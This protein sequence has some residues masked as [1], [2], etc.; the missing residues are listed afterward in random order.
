LDRFL[1]SKENVSLFSYFIDKLIKVALKFGELEN[2]LEDKPDLI[3]TIY[4][5]KVKFKS[6]IIFR[7]FPAGKEEER[8]STPEK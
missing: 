8:A 6:L 4:G 1:Q 3:S 5:G 2:L 7:S